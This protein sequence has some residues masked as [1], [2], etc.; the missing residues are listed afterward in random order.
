MLTRMIAARLLQSRD[1][2]HALN[3]YN[4]VIG[5]MLPVGELKKLEPVRIQKYYKR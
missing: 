5:T 3:L 2:A 1:G 4:D